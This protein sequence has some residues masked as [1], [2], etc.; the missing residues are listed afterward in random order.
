M[1]MRIR[2]DW[3]CTERIFRVNGIKVFHRYEQA[4]NIFHGGRRFYKLLCIQERGKEAKIVA[5]TK[6]VIN[7]TEQ[8]LLYWAWT[9]RGLVYT[10]INM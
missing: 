2:E 1:E 10:F 6:T 8:N 3:L 4:T 5:I 7:I 9:D